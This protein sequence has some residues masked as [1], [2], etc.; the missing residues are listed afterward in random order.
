MNALRSILA[1]LFL[2]T[3]HT[4]VLGGTPDTGPKEGTY[5]FQSPR[6]AKFPVRVELVL[7]KDKNGNFVVEGAVHYLDS[8]ELK[9]YSRR[10][11]TGM[12]KKS[13]KLLAKSFQG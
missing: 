5:V 1:M 3:V 6:N 10:H 4:A 7:T 11:V 2:L 12:L 8:R 13:G 9:P